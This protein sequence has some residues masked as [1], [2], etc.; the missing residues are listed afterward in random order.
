MN[1]RK[2]LFISSFNSDIIQI[3]GVAKKLYLEIKTFRDFGYSVDFI[4]IKNEGC[5]LHRE[6]NDM[7]YLCPFL[8]GYHNTFSLLYRVL[9]KTELCYNIIYFRYEHISLSMLNFFREMKK[10]NNTLIIGELPTYMG[11]PYKSSSIKIKITFYVKRFLDNYLPKKIDYLVTFSNHDKLFRI[12]TIKIENFIDLES[13]K[14]R[15]LNSK[16]RN[17]CNILTVAQLTPAHGV[18]LVIKGLYNYYK[19]TPQTRCYFHIV[20]NGDILYGLKDQV[21]KLGMKEYVI[22]HGALGGEELDEVFDKCD[23]G[24]G[25]LAIFRKKSFKLSEL[26]VREYTARALPFVYNTYE[27]QL[28]NKFFCKKIAFKEKPVDIQEIVEFYNSFEYSEYNSKKMRRFAKENFTASYQLGKINNII[29]NYFVA[30]LD[31]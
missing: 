28:E 9:K 24:I 19:S 29:K 10:K 4:E 20:G 25:A 21:E 6:N 1:K 16:K 15:N 18:D 17:T 8:N 31:K 30:T 2:L 13:T 11:Q 27:P 5:Y 26:K 22:F 12:K 14:V 7:T 23:I 3:N